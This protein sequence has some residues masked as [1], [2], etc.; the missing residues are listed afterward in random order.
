MT[1][2]RRAGR[3]PAPREHRR[4]CRRHV[5]GPKRRRA[6]LSEPPGLTSAPSAITTRRPGPRGGAGPTGCPALRSL[7]C[8]WMRVKLAW[9]AEAAGFV[10]LALDVGLPPGPGRRLPVPV[11]EL[12]NSD[13][14]GRAGPGRPEFY[15]HL[16]ES[17]TRFTAGL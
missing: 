13:G 1:F 8:A 7:V 2:R 16:P 4:D 17:Q 3:G 5:P 9:K 15:I 11:K 14:P 12:S 6:P 10:G